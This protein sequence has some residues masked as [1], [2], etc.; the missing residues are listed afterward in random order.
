M[1]SPHEFSTLLLTREAPDQVNTTCGNLVALVRRQLVI[2]KQSIDGE[3]RPSVTAIGRSLLCALGAHDGICCPS[4]FLDV[5]A[6][7]T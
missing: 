3:E 2:L 7:S 6:P 5:Q 1:L 4:S